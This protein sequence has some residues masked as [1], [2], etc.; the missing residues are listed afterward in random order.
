VSKI[1][2]A[3]SSGQKAGLLM[4]D[5]LCGMSLSG[6]CNSMSKAHDRQK[7]TATLVILPSLERSDEFVARITIQ[8]VIFDKAAR[9][10]VLERVDDAATYQQVFERIAKATF[11]QVSD[12][13]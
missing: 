8:R 11:I 12:H 5:V 9:I 6:G 2:D 4:L 7:V 13:D 10:V 3:D 1:S